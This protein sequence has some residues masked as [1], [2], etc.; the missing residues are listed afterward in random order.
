MV[1]LFDLGGVFVPDSTDVLNREMAECVGMAE[2][3]LASKWHDSLTP[4]FTGKTSIRDFYSN[5][6]TGNDPDQLLRKHIEIYLRLYRL[7]QPMVT[8]LSQVKSR[9]ATACFSNTELEIA[10]VNREKGLYAC[11]DQVFLSTELG[12]R[13]P[14]MEAF[15]TVIRTLGVPPGDVVL[16]DDKHENIAAAHAVGMKTVLFSN[17]LALAD[18]LHRLEASW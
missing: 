11:F 7:E 10:D 17:H 18:E 3:E 5:L 4:L 2:N 8:L 6:L 14:D 1:I 9:Y 12:L 13:K 15:L 16:V